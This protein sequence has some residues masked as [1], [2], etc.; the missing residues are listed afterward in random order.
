[1][2]RN[3]HASSWPPRALAPGE[4]QWRQCAY[5]AVR[6]HA[7]DAT[8]LAPRYEQLIAEDIMMTTAIQQ[9]TMTRAERR[10]RI[11]ALAEQIRAAEDAEARSAA[12][13]A[14]RSERSVRGALETLRSFES[15]RRLGQ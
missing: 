10:A 15:L 11:A 9:G 5:D 4:L 8:A 13:R 3:S 6:A 7:R 2:P 1:M 14:S 12:A